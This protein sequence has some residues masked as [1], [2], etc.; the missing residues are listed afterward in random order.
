MRRSISRPVRYSR[1]RTSELT[2][3]GACRA[4]LGFAT[5]FPRFGEQL[6]NYE[7][8]FLQ[9]Q[10]RDV[11]TGSRPPLDN[12]RR[13]ACSASPK[14]HPQLSA[15]HSSYNRP[16]RRVAANPHAKPGM[17]EFVNP[18]RARWQAINRGG[19]ARCDEPTQQHVSVLGR[20]LP[21]STPK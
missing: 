10:F 2:A 18:A 16:T 21:P 4:T 6:A 5:T 7:L 3:F 11:G 1:V 20:L 12:H 19:E 9:C 8:F 14:K 17:L 15:P 13:P